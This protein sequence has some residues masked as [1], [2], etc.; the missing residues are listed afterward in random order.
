M[1]GNARDFLSNESRKPQATGRTLARLGGY[2]VRWWPILLLALV[3]LVVSTW[4]Q[5]TTPQITGQLVDC[6]LTPSAGST[7]GNFP[8]ISRLVGNSSTNCWFAE[9]TKPA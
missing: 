5:V 2:F 4:A 3:C 9:N 8:G 7:F 1:F 6:Y